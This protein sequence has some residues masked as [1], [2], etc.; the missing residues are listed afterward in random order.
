MSPSAKNISSDIAL[1]V[2]DFASDISVGSTG[3]EGDFKNAWSDGI[4]S[5]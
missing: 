4:S 3:N 2:D 5:S 1:K